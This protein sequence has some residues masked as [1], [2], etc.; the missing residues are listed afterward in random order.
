V[1]VST[2]YGSTP[3]SFATSLPLNQRGRS[4]G[5]AIKHIDNSGRLYKA[6][7]DKIDYHIPEQHT[8]ADLAAKLGPPSGAR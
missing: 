7:V 3:M 8:R 1:I 5:F 2:S 6:G 4:R